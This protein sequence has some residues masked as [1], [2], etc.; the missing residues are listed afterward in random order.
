VAER[1]KVC[2]L[3]SYIVAGAVLAL[4]GVKPSLAQEGFHLTSPAKVTIGRD[5]GFLANNRK[6]TDTILVVQ[7]PQLT[8]SNT[9]LRRNFAASYQPEIELFDNNRNLNAWNH[10]G[11][12]S[13]AFRITERLHFKA[14]DDLVVTQDPTRSIAGS[15]L[16]L[17]RRG[18]KQNIAHVALDYSMSHKNTV[19][20]SFD[21]VAA[22]A[23]LNT[24]AFPGT[25][26]AS[27]GGTVSLAHTFKPK[28]TMTA[29]Y[30]L[31]NGKAQ[32]AGLSY[33][34]EWTHDFMVHLSAGLLKD[35]GESY[36]MSIQSEKR[37]GGVWL[38]GG[39]HRILSIFG[40][41]IPGGTPIGNDL[42]LPVAVGRHDAYHIFSAGISGKMSHRTGV[43]L[44]A[45]KTMNKSGIANR[46][47]NNVSG[48]FKLDYILA[49]RLKVYTD[50]Q[51]Y[52]QT[53]NVFVGTPIERRRYLA[54]IQ[55]DI[56]RP[57]RVSRFPEQTKPTQR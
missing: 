1:T 57:N 56:S 47:I 46:D 16:F 26:R 3:R 4:L 32:F 24:P 43:E 12:A 13:F 19:S 8:F 18:F 6:L 54:G 53:Y 41:S 38:N 37:V 5:Y 44:A 48:R 50:L 14:T 49:E 39:Y 34:A 52:N 29:T 45:A 40:S 15:L 36:L 21:N 17:P 10:T 2:V 31:L 23:P 28:R 22:S 11:T 33:E 7:P 35:G 42:V 30:S 51:F 25:G 20:F 9:S 55:F 27:N